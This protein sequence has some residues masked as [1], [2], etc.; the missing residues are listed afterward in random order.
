[1]TIDQKRR[2]VEN[3]S[4]E[5]SIQ[6]QCDA[7]GLARSSFYYQVASETEENLLLMR[8][9]D[10][11]YMRC[12]FY[13]YRRMTALLN[14][15]GHNINEKRILRLMRLMGLEALYPKPNLSM[16]QEL[17]KRYP[18]LLKGVK[19][20][21][22]DQV[23]SADITYIPLRSGFLY[24]VAIIDW[25]SRYCLSWELS[26]TMDEAFC[27]GA[28]KMAL[29]N[30]KPTIFNTDQGAQFTGNMFTGILEREE[31]QISWDGKGR[32][33]DNVF[34]ERVWR[35]LK[36]ENVYPNRYESALEATLGISKYFDFYNNERPHQSL[37]Y[38]T[39]FE[40]YFG[41]VDEK[42]KI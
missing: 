18:Y 35:S 21:K 11:E 15:K 24:L 14:R 16:S 30:G 13:G 36:Y 22:R 2:L 42:W 25:Y 1:M 32:A 39:P 37:K 29:K 31:I 8:L 40:V 20:E 6:A 33:L 7:L 12:P 10:E 19:I 23:W 26:N 28:L 17:K 27:L 34:I 4:K 9:I 5:L 41:K 3:A 38:N